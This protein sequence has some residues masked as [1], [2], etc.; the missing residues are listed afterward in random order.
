M[1]RVSGQKGDDGSVNE[2][3][4]RIFEIHRD[5]H[6]VDR[7]DLPQTPVGLA[8]M[9]DETAGHQRC[10]A[11]RMVGTCQIFHHFSC[12]T[13]VFMVAPFRLVAKK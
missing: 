4:P 9:K 12:S 11:S 7:L 1:I 5:S 2:L 10:A 3:F 13:V 8:G 6:A